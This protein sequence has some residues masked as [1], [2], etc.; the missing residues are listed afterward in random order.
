MV[1]CVYITRIWQVEGHHK[2][3]EKQFETKKKTPNS[4]FKVFVKMNHLQNGIWIIIGWL[5]YRFP[6]FLSLIK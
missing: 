5:T 2:P 6:Y 3:I 1:K 4:L